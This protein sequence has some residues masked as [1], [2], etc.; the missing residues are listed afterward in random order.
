[1]VSSR[2]EFVDFVLETMLHWATV[3]SRKMFGGYGL[4]RDELMFAL[5]ADDTLYFKTDKCNV[6]QFERA[7]SLPFIYRNKTR[8]VQMP[9]WSAPAECLE[10]PD[11]M[12]NWCSL[13]YAA[14]LRSSTKK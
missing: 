9:Y 6:T 7:G 10:S 2:N 13:A 4:Y 1:M 8:I 3:N 14:A 5:I 12:R 11:E